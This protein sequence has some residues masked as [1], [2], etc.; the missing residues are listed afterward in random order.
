MTELPGASAFDLLTRIELQDEGTLKCLW[1]H[2]S[3]AVFS[4]ALR[5]LKDPAAAEDIV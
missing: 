1:D 5:I 2:Y 4:I 3:K